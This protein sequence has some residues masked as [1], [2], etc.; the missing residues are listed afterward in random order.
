M[1]S[2]AYGEMVPMPTRPPVKAKRELPSTAIDD[3]DVSTSDTWNGAET[4]EEADEMNPPSKSASPANDEVDEAEKRSDTR[5]GDETVEEASEMKLPNVASPL[6]VIVPIPVMF[7]SVSISQS[8][9][10]IAPV[11]PPSPSANKPFASSVLSAVSVPENVPATAVSVAAVVKLSSVVSS[12]AALRYKFVSR[13]SPNAMPF[14]ASVVST[15]DESQRAAVSAPS[16]V[17][18]KSA[19]APAVMSSI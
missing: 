10:S 5:N 18:P 17:S 16:I 11:S 12:F 7:P 8:L 14:A 6:D 19:V 2:F 3:D 15:A 1:E 4:V 13:E 9:V